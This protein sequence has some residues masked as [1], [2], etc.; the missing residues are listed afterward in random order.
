MTK[1]YDNIMFDCEGFS[2]RPNALLV[3]IAAVP[4]DLSAAPLCPH[5]VEM[6]DAYLDWNKCEL[7]RNLCHVDL[8]T[9][10]WW[11]AQGQIARNRLILG[12]AGALNAMKAAD[13]LMHF[14][15]QHGTDDVKVWSY[16][17]ASDLVW[18]RHFL[19]IAGYPEPWSYRNERCLRTV[20][21]TLPPAH[22]PEPK[23]A[24]DALSDALAQVEW[25]CN[26]VAHR[27][28]DAVNSYVLALGGDS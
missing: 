25:L 11:M 28:R 24:H 8:A 10:Y 3:Q 26:I 19:H 20:A 15:K 2:T 7:E 14:I 18:L 13:Q 1:R 16:G 4:F 21:A 12:H 22:R 6:F 17:A 9:V 5:G 23:I 27:G